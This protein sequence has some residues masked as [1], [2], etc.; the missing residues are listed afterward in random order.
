MFFPGGIFKPNRV[1]QDN[2]VCAASE[3]STFYKTVRNLFALFCF[4]DCSRP[5]TGLLYAVGAAGLRVWRSH[6]STLVSVAFV[7]NLFGI[8]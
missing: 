5:R 3:Y 6:Q 2:F 8:M 1:G 7:I 4:V